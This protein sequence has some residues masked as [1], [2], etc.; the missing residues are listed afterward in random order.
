MSQTTKIPIDR[1]EAY[2]SAFTKR[3]LL[4]GNP[5]AADIE[6]LSPELGDQ[7]VSEGDRLNGITYDPK[8]NALELSLGFPLEDPYLHRIYAPQEVWVVEESDGF[9]SSI[10][11]VRAAGAREVVTVRKVGLRPLS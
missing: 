4:H 1:L 8:A 11:I 10:A 7:Y 6:V 9:T 5:E 3:F 2:F